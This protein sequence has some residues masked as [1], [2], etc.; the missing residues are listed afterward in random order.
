MKK[1]ARMQNSIRANQIESEQ[2]IFY[3]SSIEVCLFPIRIAIG[4]N[5][6]DSYLFY[7]RY[8]AQ[9]KIIRPKV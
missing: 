7:E 9:A 5:R 2:Y 6:I 3:Q 1:N 4:S 8:H